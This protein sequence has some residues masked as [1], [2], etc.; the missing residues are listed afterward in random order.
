VAR[1]VAKCLGFELTLN[2]NLP[3][4]AT[5][6]KDFW[7]RWHISL[8]HWLRDY[9]SIK[10]GGDRGGRL[11]VYRNL[12]L[13]MILGGLWHG[14][15]WTYAVG[16]F[17]Q[18]LLQVGHRLASPWLERVQPTD[19]VDRGYWK[20]FRIFATFDLVCLGWLIFRAGSLKQALGMLSA[21]ASRPAIPAASHLVPVLVLIVP[22]WIVQLIQYASKDQDVI[23]RTPWSSAPVSSTA[24]CL[25]RTAYWKLESILLQPLGLPR[26]ASTTC[27]AP[28]PG[29]ADSRPPSSGC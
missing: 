3:Y 13:T 25:L 26:D 17:Y 19:P 27:T 4:F 28:S 12:M 18:G 6:P 24:D 29:R 5:S 2:F 23:A 16:G 8:S 10:V 7:N 21:I 11:K 20:A 14:A 1:G 22:L 15:A 9:L